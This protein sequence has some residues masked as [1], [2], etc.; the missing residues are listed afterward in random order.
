MSQD[1][2]NAILV[3]GSG[4][5]GSSAALTAL[6]A[7]LKVI[8]VEKEKKLGGNSVRASS[9]INASETH[10]QKE[11]KIKD[12]NE[13]FAKDTVYSKDKDRDAIPTDLIWTLCNNSAAGV[14]WIEDHG[15]SI[16]V[17]S[18][19][20]GH[21]ASRTHRP[22][23]GAAGGYITLGLV[24]HV[25]S[26]EEK[27]QCKIIKQAKLTKLLKDNNG[28]VIGIEYENLANGKSAELKGSAVI[29]AT[30]GFLYNDQMLKEYCPHVANLPTTNGPWTTGD[31]MQIAKSSGAG[32]VDMRH[33][34]V[35]P[36]G[37]VDQTKPHE[38]E[39]TLAAECLRAAGALLINK[40]GHRFVNELG[41]RDDVTAAERGQKGPI[42]LILNPVAVSECEPHTRMYRDFFKVLK[43]YKNAQA[44]ADDM[45]IPVENLVDTFESYNQ[46]ARKGWCPS[47]KERFPGYPYKADQE[48]HA[49]FV[50]PVLHYVMGGI[51]IDTE[52]HVLT[53]EGKIIPGLFACGE[54]TGGIHGRNRLAGNS[55]VDCVVYG[56][57]AGQSARKYSS[58]KLKSKL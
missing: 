20:G 44:L 4:L 15:L 52:A 26:Y 51:K 56:R 45:K 6:E 12:S 14:K 9:G 23:T 48:L 21:S 3:I 55:L 54:T 58:E 33:V 42:R 22:V 2:S 47:G 39:K 19:N 27:G 17:L 16:P 53:K 43:I 13:L 18:Q 57:I 8:V 41:H 24:K 40:D 31:G 46:S 37:F 7:G 5:S 49:G 30:G 28:K 10:H 50:V 25:R 35:H 1:W 34:Q 11:Q 38:R 29:I 36:T 32:L